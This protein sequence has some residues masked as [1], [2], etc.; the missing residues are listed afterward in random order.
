MLKQWLLMKIDSSTYAGKHTRLRGVSS[1]HPAIEIMWVGDGN[2]LIDEYY[3]G[4]DLQEGWYVFVDYTKP[5]YGPF[6]TSKIALEEYILYAKLAGD[7][8]ASISRISL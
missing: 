8:I 6:Q 5:I 4:C 7:K 3:R 1:E 2:S